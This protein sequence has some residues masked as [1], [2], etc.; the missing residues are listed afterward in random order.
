MGLTKY[1]FYVKGERKNKFALVR[2]NN[3]TLNHET[4][5]FKN[6]NEDEA[7]GF[8]HAIDMG[9]IT[10]KALNKITNRETKKRKKAKKKNE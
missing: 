8:I 9:W 1:G 10:E 6:L 4:P 7:Y 5:V 2:K 3:H